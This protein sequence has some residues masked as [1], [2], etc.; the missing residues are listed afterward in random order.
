MKTKNNLEYIRHDL[1]VDLGF[2][3]LEPDMKGADN[4]H[5]NFET[6]YRHPHLDPLN[7][8][9]VNYN[10]GSWHF[11]QSKHASNGIGK[12]VWLDDLLKGFKFVTDKDLLSL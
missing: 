9:L 2:E 11:A 4:Y 8:I 3:L 5:W 12:M 7:L 10:N 1:L 6:G